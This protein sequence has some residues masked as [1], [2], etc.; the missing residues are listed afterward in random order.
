MG[1]K[2]YKVQK[3]KTKINAFLAKY[4]YP[5]PWNKKNEQFLISQPDFLLLILY[6]HCR[7]Q[8]DLYRVQNKF[9]GAQQEVDRLSADLEKA[10][11]M[12]SKHKDDHKS[13]SDELHALQEEFDESR[14][15]VNFRFL[16]C[17]SHAVVYHFNF[18][19][20][21]NAMIL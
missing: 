10:N 9:E 18:L 15:Q 21:A 20:F 5:Y 17:A 14:L 13:V 19:T 8:G 11:Y 2:Y 12:A 6:I 7:A 16:G 3:I 4:G 1:P